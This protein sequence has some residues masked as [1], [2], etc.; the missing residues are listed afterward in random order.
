MSDRPSFAAQASAV[1]DLVNHAARNQTLGEPALSW[2]RQAAVTLG[3]LAEFEQPIREF[4]RLSKRH[5]ALAELLTALPGARIADVREMDGG[6]REC[7]L[8]GNGFR[9]GEGKEDEAWSG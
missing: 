5:P 8:A 3:A 2:A 4:Y 9:E 7:V 6:N 1:T